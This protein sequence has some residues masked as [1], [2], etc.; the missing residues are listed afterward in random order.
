MSSRIKNLV[1]EF[2][3][4]D[5]VKYYFR[6]KTKRLGWFNSGKKNIRFYLRDNKSDQG[7]FSQVFAQ[8]QYDFKLHFEPKLI[9]DAGANIGMSALY[10]ASKFPQARIVALE[11]DKENFEIALQNTK[12]NPKIKLLHKGVWHRDVF[13]EIID[14]D[15]KQDSFMVKESIANTPGSIEAITISTILQQENWKEIDILKIDIEGAEKE[16]F[17]ENY[18][19]WLPYTKVL[20]VEVHDQ[21]K[22]GSSRAVFKAT[23]QYNFS[24][25]MKH[26]NLIF[27][28]EDL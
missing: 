21:M 9:I 16:L 2:G 1:K 27:I 14:A 25:T 15:A 3:I 20:F 7:I 10:F 17:S 6:I 5:G 28:N 18:E 12:D 19:K 4:V 23:S 13:L 22:K 24:F 8:Q 11:A 26:E